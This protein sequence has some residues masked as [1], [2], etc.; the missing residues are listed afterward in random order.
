MQNCRLLFKYKE[1]LKILIGSDILVRFKSTCSAWNQKKLT[2][3]F[4]GT[5]QFSLR[6][7]VLLNDSQ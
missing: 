3:L 2:V 4:F 5:D 6:S 1:K 7:L